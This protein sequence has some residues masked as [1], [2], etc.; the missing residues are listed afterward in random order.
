MAALGFTFAAP[1]PQRLLI[2]GA[3]ADDAEIGAGGF[4]RVLIARRPA[5][6]IHWVVFCAAGQRQAEAAASAQEILGT[7]RG[8][9]F[10]THAFRDGF[11]PY[12]GVRIKEE[13]ERLKQGYEPDLVLSHHRADLHQDHRVIAE[14]TWNTFRSH[15]ILEYEIPTYD[16]DLGSP[17]FFVPLSAGIIQEKVDGLMKHFASQRGKSWF[18]AET[19][20]A[21][22]RLRGMECRSES[23]FAEA[24]YLRKAVWDTD[25]VP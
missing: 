1:S 19:F 3:H 5:M 15:L 6:R 2:L 25:G 24:F 18:S 9:T 22:M 10:E 12:E 14:L 20:E 11:F 13:F 7:E 21:I 17:N 16:G 8:R 4:V 23:G